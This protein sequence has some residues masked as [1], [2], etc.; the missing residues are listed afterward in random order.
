MHLANTVAYML[1][2]HVDSTTITK[3]VL[4]TILPQI[5]TTFINLK[6]DE[7]TKAS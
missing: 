5:L 2:E 6:H 3:L 7:L 4:E 1:A